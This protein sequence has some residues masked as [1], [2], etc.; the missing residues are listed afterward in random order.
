MTIMA[1]ELINQI[2]QGALIGG[3]YVLFAIGLSLSLGVMRFVNIAHGDL[4]VL[5]SF[6]LMSCSAILGLSPFIAAAL[7]MP[8]AFVAFYGLQRLLLQRLVGTNLLGVILVTFGLAIVIQNGLLQTYGPDTRKLSGGALELK[9]ISIGGGLSIGLFP[10]LVFATAVIV[11]FALDRFLY[12]TSIGSRIR[13]VADDP[14]AANLIGLPSAKIY[15]IA[16]GV[17]GLTVMSAASCMS[18]WTNFD[19]EIGPSRL[20]IAFEVVVLGGLGSL[21]G[22]LVGGIIIGVAQNLGAQ[23]DAA[24]QI[25]AQHLVFLVILFLR[26]QGLFPRGSRT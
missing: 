6:I 12:R 11:I 8:V 18:V 5:A 19:P 25:L 9:S 21:W 3:L 16:M 13:A 23:L 15:G 1:L 26:P 7:L 17:V 22:T 14:S 20:L 10:L 2:I 4:I 24:W